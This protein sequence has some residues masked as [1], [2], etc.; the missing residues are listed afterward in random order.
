MKKGGGSVGILDA[1]GKRMP[2][3]G[4]LRGK[5]L[6]NGGKASERNKKKT[7]SWG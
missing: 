5:S 2:F 1:A 4:G 3:W 7:H 6:E